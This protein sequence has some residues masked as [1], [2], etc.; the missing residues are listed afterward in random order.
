MEVLPCD[1][2]TK[3]IELPVG[4]VSAAQVEPTSSRYG[5]PKLRSCGLVSGL[6][7]SGV[8]MASS[9]VVMPCLAPARQRIAWLL[10]KA[11]ARKLAPP[12]LEVS[13]PL[14]VPR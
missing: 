10:G 11:L 9:R 6:G 7:L 3:R 12:V 4:S 13:R 5:A 1:M 14:L 2:A 8:V